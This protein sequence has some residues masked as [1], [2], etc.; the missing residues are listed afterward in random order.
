M[1]VI[2]IPVADQTQLQEMLSLVVA[3]PS[4][5]FTSEL[6]GREEELTLRAM[7]AL[8]NGSI[9]ASEFNALRPLLCLKDRRRHLPHSL[10]G[11]NFMAAAKRQIPTI[12]DSLKTT[13]ASVDRVRV[14]R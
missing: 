8:R 3:N 13:H 7:E 2:Q 1:N 12:T 4:L 9:S 5:F 6:S 10:R 14:W 11:L